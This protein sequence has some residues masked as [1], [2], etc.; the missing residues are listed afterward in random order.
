LESLNLAG[1]QQST[2]PAESLRNMARSCVIRFLIFYPFLTQVG[3]TIRFDDST[4]SITRIKYL[5]D[6]MLLRELQ[7]SP[8]LSAYSVIILDEAHE[9][10]LRTD[11]LMGL[12][13]LILPLRPELRIV[14]MSATLDAERFSKFF[15]IDGKEAQIAFVQGREYPVEILNTADLTTNFDH[16]GNGDYIHGAL[17]CIMQIHLSNEEGDILVFLTGT[18][19]VIFSETRSK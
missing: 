11:L 8:T 14:I 5:T 12:I 10:S 9:R 2:W 4:S 3:Y 17:K 13:K 15:E 6:G 7:S 18:V 19:H 16:S 1:W